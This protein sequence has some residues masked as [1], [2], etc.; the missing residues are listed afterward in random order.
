MN[1]NVRSFKRNFSTLS[2][3]FNDFNLP[4]IFCLSETRF[5]SNYLGEI[6][7]FDAF[8]TYR[9]SNTPAGG[10]SLFI[11][12]RFKAKQLNSLSY[13]NDTIEI[14][15][16]EFT[17]GKQH[18]VILGIYRPHSDT[19]D[20]FNSFISEILNCNVLKNK[21]CIILGDLNVC[22]LKQNAPNLD[23]TN[24]LFSHHFNPL[25][26]K[27]TRF[28]QIEGEVPSLLDHIWIN[29]YFDVDAGII[30]LDV[31]DH[32][33]TYANFK[34]GTTIKD[35]KIKIAFRIIN[36][37]N[38]LKFEQNL[39]RTNWNIIK[40]QDVDSYA[41]SFI[42][43]L[44]SI[45]CSAFPLKI[46]YISKKHSLNP[47]MTEPLKKLIEAK[48]HYFQLY[49]MSLVTLAENNQFRNK[50][51]DIIRKHKSKFYADLLT[52]SKNDLKKTWKI[53]N[54]LLSKN[55]KTKEISKI[56]FN[57]IPY[58]NS[59]D[60]ATMF[61]KYFCSIGELYDSE[62]PASDLDPCH[63][64][65]VNHPSYFFLEPV[66]PFEVGFHIKSLKNSKQDIDS[67]SISILKENHESLSHTIADLINTCF[68]TGIKPRSFKKA[69]VLPLYKKDDPE[70]MSNYRPISIL[71][72]L[73]KIIEKC[74]KT[75]L[76]HYFMRN[77]L[78]NQCQ[79][80]FQ[81]GMST[82]D[83]ILYLTE[84]IYVNLHESLSTLAIYIDFSKCFD[85][86]NRSILLK[87]LE[88]YGIRGIPLNL[89]KSYLS[90][91]YQCVK[92][93][94][95]T[96]NFQLIDTGVPQGSVLGPILYLIY[97]NEIP[98]ISNQ[99]S[100][101]LFAD[102]TT[103][104]FKHANKYDLFKSCDYG[105]NL[106][107]SW[108]CS[109]RL[110]I[111]ISKTKCML[112]SNTLTQFDI[113]DIYMNHIKIEYTS[114][115][116]FLGVIMDDKLKFNIHINEINKKISK[117][118]GVIYRLKQYA[119]ISTL[120]AV[121]RSIIECYLNYCNLIFGNS[122]Q[123]HIS[124]LIISQKKAVRMI[125]NNPPF[126]HSNPIFLNLNLLKVTDIYKYN[127]AIYMFR[128][129]DR[130]SQNFRINTHNTRSGNYYTPSYQ[131]L[132]LGQH[133]SIMYQAPLNWEKIPPSVKNSRSLASFKRK[134]KSY[135]VSLYSQEA[136]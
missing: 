105:V 121:Y 115:T 32:L 95:V 23:F 9:D 60:I 19:I 29:K 48:S 12:D 89:F 63:F 64:I 10:I 98:N 78:L 124:S 127:L 116:R 100:T 92:I 122:F 73:S 14:I 62:I 104:I 102:D 66:S 97:V 21:F 3:I 70:L 120:V 91:R 13:C 86:L 28:P 71:P 26:T 94:N 47:W 36:D 44:N 72:T 74:L 50:V 111:N 51:N 114:S 136:S 132:T 5:S 69:V 117:N 119:P 7:G 81:A 110:S 59:S 17:F 56:I 88:R 2:A 99:F 8:H 11:N 96:S 109:N 80:G 41:D 33:P 123:T 34:F 53:I 57:N 87:K 126:A 35:E 133:Q 39:A 83:A 20:N 15:T 37:E 118:I 38:K 90:D 106:F 22:L 25:I 131:R 24:L 107:Y 85:T 40:S 61:N 108:C 65:K 46:K 134:Y 18:I 1:S 16:A 55:I 54:D 52:K 49:R 82:Q 93:N 58:T 75:R 76:L 30:K 77:N 68:Q 42:S 6:S 113:A 135:L 43:T 125:T 103:L 45:Y 112:F 79:F 84:K 31:S 128:N 67:I 27:P 129:I 4:S 130:F 101:C